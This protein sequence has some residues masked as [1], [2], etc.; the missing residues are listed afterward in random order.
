MTCHV[1]YRPPSERLRFLCPTCAR[2]ELYPLRID[3]VNALLEKDASGREIENAV[4]KNE[5]GDAGSEAEPNRWS[6]Q[7]ANTRA[8]QSTARAQLMKERM[9]VLRKEI[10]EGKKEV[11]QRRVAL[12]Q[13][14]SDAGS[15]NYRISDRRAA[16]VSEV[17]HEIQR[18][19]QKWTGLHS[20]FIESRV[21]LC[22]EAANLY[23]LRQRTR[24]R[25][26][27]V[28]STYMIGGISIIDLRDLNSKSR[29]KRVLF[30]PADIL[31]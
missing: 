19:E 23:G 12:A 26:G 22:R 5:G 9:A 21:F 20:K 4:E 28:I 2:N 17:Q 14:R 11:A 18:T 30:A 27:E 15:V 25:K 7:A 29:P 1:C 8:S 10:A 31:R 3:Q 13:R 16:A 6:I 24:R